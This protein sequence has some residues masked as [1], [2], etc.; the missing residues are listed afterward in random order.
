MDSPIKYARTTDGVNIAYQCTGEGP[1]LVYIAP[2]GSL[3]QTSQYPLTRSW[4]ERLSAHHQVVR[5]DYR[6]LG[7]SDRGWKF[8]A[9]LTAGDVQAV[10]DRE[11]LQR[12]ALLGMLHTSATAICFAHEHPQAVSQ[13]VLWSPY[14][15]HRAYIENSAPLRAAIAAGEKDWQTLSELIGLQA[16]GWQDAGQA[17]S[18]AAYLR[19]GASPDHYV[20]MEDFDVTP[21]L[22]KLQ[23]PVLVMHRR[24]I[25][26]P[27]LELARQVAM[28]IPSARFVL[29]EGA[30]MLP[31]FGDTEAVLGAIHDFLTETAA[32]APPSR[33]DGLTERETEIL[34]LLAAGKS[35]AAIAQ[36]L[37]ISTRTVERHIG[38]I[39][40]KIGVHSRSEATAYAFR[41]G[42]A[43]G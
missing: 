26:F 20:D 21:L 1:P 29:M 34:A 38:N 10:A 5:L 6:G 16:A 13:L 4:M 11:D 9:S 39:Y 15:N 33:R 37:T 17:R 30:E 8:S 27:P 41:H 25:Q 28:S 18:F 31:F 24:E 32:P 35:N 42:I 2:G 19:A 12:F 40:V 36:A 7:L 3:G 22:G 14:A 23:M 43:A